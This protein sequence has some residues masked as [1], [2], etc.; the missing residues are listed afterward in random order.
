LL[1]YARFAEAVRRLSCTN[2]MYAVWNY[3]FVRCATVSWMSVLTRTVQLYR[4]MTR[5]CPIADLK[6]EFHAHKHT[7]TVKSRLIDVIIG[8]LECDIVRPSIEMTRTHG[9]HASSFISSKHMKPSSPVAWILV[10]TGV[11]IRIV[12]DPSTS[13]AN[14]LL[15]KSRAWRCRLV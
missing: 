15:T 2:V 1:D 4:P 5:V 14:G 8:D 3:E 6:G 10:G 11:W 7:A 13:T 9:T 12:A